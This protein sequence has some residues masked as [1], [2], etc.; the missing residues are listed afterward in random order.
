MTRPSLALSR[1][2]LSVRLYFLAMAFEKPQ[3]PVKL[4]PFC[5]DVTE[6]TQAAYGA[7]VDA[8]SCIPPRCKKG[9]DAG[10]DPVARSKYPVVCID[11]S[12]ARAFCAFVGKRLPTEAEWELAAR[13]AER[14]LFPWGE[15]HPRCGDVVFGRGADLPSGRNC[16]NLDSTPDSVGRSKQDV[17]PDGVFDL[18][19]NVLE[20]VQD[21]FEERYASCDGE[22]KDPVVDEAAD[23]GAAKGKGGQG[24]QGAKKSKKPEPVLRVVRGGS[25]NF[26]A[27]ACRGAGRSRQP[28]DVA[29]GN[30]GFRCAKTVTQ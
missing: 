16:K 24:S 11:W 6:V 14:R 5:I 23:G 21:R 13:G 20:W 19:G 29:Q 9:R 1:S 10:W 30:V 2:S 28:Q 18:G 22:C 26:P 25:Y 12:E 15:K 17:T 8:G 4:A 3:H 7:C 27:D